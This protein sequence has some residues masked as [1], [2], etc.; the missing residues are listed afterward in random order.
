ML[1]AFKTGMGIMNLAYFL[2][3]FTLWGYMYDFVYFVVGLNLPVML[4]GVI[5]LTCK[6]TDTVDKIKRKKLILTF[7]LTFLNVTQAMYGASTSDVNFCLSKW[8]RG[9]SSSLVGI[10][11]NQNPPSLPHL[12]FSFGHPPH[13]LS[14]RCL[15]VVLS[16]TFPVHCIHILHCTIH[17]RSQPHGRAYGFLQGVF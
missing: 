11:S 15:S 4:C 14:H 7:L 16:K 9:K 2:Y 3:L 1:K 5:A 13:V 6:A 8:I 12:P 10:Q 17:P